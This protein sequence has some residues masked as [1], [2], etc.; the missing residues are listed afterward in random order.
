MYQQVWDLDWGY[1]ENCIAVAPIV[2][3]SVQR[4][5][6]VDPPKAGVGNCNSVEV[7]TLERSVDSIERVNYFLIMGPLHPH[8]VVDRHYTIAHIEMEVLYLVVAMVPLM[9]IDTVVLLRLLAGPGG[10]L[11]VNQVLFRVPQRN[12]IGY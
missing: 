5:K 12:E 9:E 8:M 2:L 11:L 1:T 7:R 6:V 10:P 3:C 4:R